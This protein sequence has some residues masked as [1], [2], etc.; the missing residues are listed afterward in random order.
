MGEAAIQGLLDSGSGLNVGYYGYWADFAER[1]PQ[2]VVNFAPMDT[3]EHDKILVGGI[4]KE[5]PAS[6]CSHFIEIITPLRNEGKPVSIRIALAQNFAATLIIGT[7][8][9]VRGRMVIHMAE[10]YVF[11]NSFQKAFHIQYLVPHLR[12]TVPN[13]D[14]QKAK[15]FIATP[16]PNAI[17]PSPPTMDPA[18]MGDRIRRMFTRNKPKNQE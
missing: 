3:E 1:Y 14:G 5:D 16:R 9:L 11:S 18:L 12:E 7:P 17:Q 8:F 6:A 13:Q 4:S 2:Y 15:T 10:S